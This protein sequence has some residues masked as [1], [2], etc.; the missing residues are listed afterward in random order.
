M[1]SLCDKNGFDTLLGG[2]GVD[3]M[4]WFGTSPG[5]SDGQGAGANCMV[6]INGPNPWAANCT[7]PANF[8]VTCL[9]WSDP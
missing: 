2:A 4:S 1:D 3:K 5:P 9:P 8:T 6:N 7:Q